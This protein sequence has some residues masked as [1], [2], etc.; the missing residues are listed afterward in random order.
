MAAELIL[1]AEASALPKRFS[2]MRKDKKLTDYS[3]STLSR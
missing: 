3:Y 2:L 1:E